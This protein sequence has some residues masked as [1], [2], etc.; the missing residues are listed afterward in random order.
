MVYLLLRIQ[1]NLENLTSTAVFLVSPP[2]NNSDPE[3]LE[4]SCRCSKLL[5]ILIGERSCVAASLPPP[6]L[7]CEVWTGCWRSS[8]QGRYGLVAIASWMTS[9]ELVAKL[10]A[11]K[12]LPSAYAQ[13][14]TDIYNS[15]S[16]QEGFFIAASHLNESSPLQIGL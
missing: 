9:A 4:S 3:K 13:H 15:Y 10:E 8:K 11:E 7:R 2:K 1:Q 6:N 14:R 5:R 16:E 12:T